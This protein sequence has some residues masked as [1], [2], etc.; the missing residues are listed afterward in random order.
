MKSKYN[1]RI[2]YVNFEDDIV[3]IGWSA[4]GVG[5]GVLSIYWNDLKDTYYIET[6]T[7]GKEFCEQVL[8]EAQKYILHKS[9]IIE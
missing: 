2:N 5:F 7:M 4:K 9:V 8:N 6:E 3:F 1:I